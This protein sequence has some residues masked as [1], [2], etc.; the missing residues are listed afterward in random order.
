LGNSA[1]GLPV[2]RGPDRHW[3]REPVAPPRLDLFDA[4]LRVSA[5]KMRLGQLALSDVGAVLSL[6]QGQL[7]I[8]LAGAD[9]YS[10]KLKGRIGAARNEDNG[11]DL[12]ATASFTNVDAASFLR[13]VAR[14]QRISGAASGDLSLSSSGAS[15]AGVMQRLNGALRMVVRKGEIGGLDVEQAVRRAEKRPLS[16]PSEMRSG[17]TTFATADLSAKITEGVMELDRA[18]VAGLGV[19]MDVSGMVSIADRS[20]RLDIAASAPPSTSSPAREP[21]LHLDVIGP[22]EDPTL[23]IDTESLIRRSKAAA[24]LLR[25]RQ[26]PAAP[27]PAAAAPAVTAAD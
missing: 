20:I 25:E 2:M 5:G 23:K 17:Q 7:E 4:D 8:T 27:A 16:I 24:P 26:P 10:G 21:L 13:D 14:V 12:R 19:E 18:T 15:V 11:L 9:A 3:S 22:W 6:N 1:L